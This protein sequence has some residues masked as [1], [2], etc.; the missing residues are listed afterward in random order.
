MTTTINETEAYVPNARVCAGT[1]EPGDFMRV[2]S[3][4]HKVAE[5]DWYTVEVPIEQT[6]SYNAATDDFSRD[7]VTE[8]R[9][10]IT[11][12]DGTTIKRRAATVVDIQERGSEVLPRALPEDEWSEP[13]ML[14]VPAVTNG[15]IWW[16]GC[17]FDDEDRMHFAARVNGKFEVTAERG[18]IAVADDMRPG[19]EPMATTIIWQVLRTAKGTPRQLAQLFGWTVADMADAT[20]FARTGHPVPGCKVVAGHLVLRSGRRINLRAA[21]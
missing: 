18:S 13:E 11:L 6:T 7:F 14:F 5:V 1:V 19:V 21:R 2:G 17:H 10:T 20:L 4:Y 8:E 15:R 3:V 9:C 16:F 12:H